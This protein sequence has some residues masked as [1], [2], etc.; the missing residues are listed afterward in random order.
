MAKM[1]QQEAPAGAHGPPAAAPPA[2]APA[3]LAAP[4]ALVPEPFVPIEPT[5]PV[6]EV[7]RCEEGDGVE[8]RE[9]SGAGLW[10]GISARSE[11]VSDM[12]DA[13]L[14][15]TRL[16]WK[17]LGPCLARKCAQGME[18]ECPTPPAPGS[19]VWQEEHARAIAAV[20]TGLAPAADVLAHA[21]RI[22]RRGLS[23]VLTD[24]EGGHEMTAAH[25]VEVARGLAAS[26]L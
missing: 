17:P 2:A 11:D 18:C 10:L 24:A 23:E 15:D 13:F 14:E 26:L 5:S 21:K 22:L 20:P 8:N 12:L 25:A 4:V 19:F 6:A 1:L 7:A 16:V 9:G 3:P